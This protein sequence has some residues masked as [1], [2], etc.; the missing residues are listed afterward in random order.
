MKWNEMSNKRKQKEQ[1][2]TCAHRTLCYNELRPIRRH[3]LFWNILLRLK[4]HQ[5][6][7][8]QAV[9]IPCMGWEVMQKERHQTPE[10]SR[11]GFITHPLC[12]EVSS[13]LTWTHKNCPININ[14]GFNLPAC[15][16]LGS[17]EVNSTPA[18]TYGTSGS[19]V[20]AYKFLLPDACSVPVQS[21]NNFL[22]HTTDTYIVEARSCANA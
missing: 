5:F 4:R 1:K 19:Y 20:G 13:V 18:P 22:S 11:T 12:K 8:D 16:P 7:L 15:A 14:V 10:N 21:E 17:T 9:E 2:C 6:N 3:L